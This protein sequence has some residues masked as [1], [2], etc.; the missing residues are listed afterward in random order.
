MITPELIMAN[1]GLLKLDL[2]RQGAFIENDA[3]T[4]LHERGYRVEGNGPFGGVDDVDI[5]LARSAEA[6]MG[7][8]A[9]SVDP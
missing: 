8:T 6:L 4:S 3:L 1:P 7:P 5:L 9:G 2:M